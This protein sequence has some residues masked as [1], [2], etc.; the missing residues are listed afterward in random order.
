MPDIRRRLEAVEART[1]QSKKHR[2]FIEREGVIRTGFSTNSKVIPREEF[3]V[4]DA[5]PDYDVLLLRMEIVKP[6]EALDSRG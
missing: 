4:I 6:H 5:D 3:D 1:V 2:V